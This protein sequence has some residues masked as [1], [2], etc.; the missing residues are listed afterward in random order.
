MGLS[1]AM[2]PLFSPAGRKVLAQL[3]LD[4]T[5]IAFDFDG[6]LA[7][8]VEEPEAARTLAPLLPLLDRLEDTA[9]IAVIT[10]RA[11]HDVRR[12]LDFSPDFVV[13]NHGMEG[14]PEFR[15]KADRARDIC[16]RW[17]RELKAEMSRRRGLFLEDK[18]YSL[19]LH[20]RQARDVQAAEKWL[21]AR[22]KELDP[23]PRVIP[24]KCLFNLVPKNSP[25]KG[26]ALKALMK[27]AQVK[28]ALFIGDDDTDEDVFVQKGNILSVR[29]GK[30]RGSKARFYIP[31]QEDM[32][33]LLA[34]LLGRT[35]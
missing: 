4:K 35:K 2:K 13:G 33:P 11:V 8:I 12:R 25:D 1:R 31:R 19:S 26:A 3:D 23:A 27:R 20:Y 14:L 22:I 28:Q 17:V 21:K 10:G 29:I 30:K 32:L 7:P 6:T 16:R 24:G 34:E 15:V 5:L 18:R 9:K